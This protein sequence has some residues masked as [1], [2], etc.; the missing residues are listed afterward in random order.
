MRRD[1]WLLPS[2]GHGR[3]DTRADTHRRTDIRAAYGAASTRDMAAGVWIQAARNVVKA[4]ARRPNATVPAARRGRTGRRIRPRL[5]LCGH[6]PAR[7][8]R[9]L[10]PLRPHVRQHAARIRNGGQRPAR[11]LLPAVLCRATASWSEA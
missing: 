8:Q 7:A 6:A 5:F 11:K 4:G 9:A 3:S 10:L 2:V 1:P